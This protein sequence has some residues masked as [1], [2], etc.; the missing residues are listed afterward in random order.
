MFHDLVRLRNR[1]AG[2][3]GV[4]AFAAACHA[5]AAAGEPPEVRLGAGMDVV[6]KSGM[7]MVSLAVRPLSV[8]VWDNRNYGL[9]LSYGF[10]QRVGWNA[11]VG[12]MLVRRTD[13]DVGTRLNLLLR[14]S[15]CG[16]SVCLSYAHLSHGSAL[17]IERRKAN[18]GLNF[19]FLEYRYR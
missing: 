11:G 18:S 16:Q 7:A 8:F 15:Y 3:A 5:G 9:G 19:V 1:A 14:G 4:L 6:H 12:G 17:G 10:G 2:L 13:D